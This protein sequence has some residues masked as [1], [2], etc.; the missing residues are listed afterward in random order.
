MGHPLLQLNTTIKK[1]AEEILYQKGLHQV[2]NSFGK[3][4]VSGSYSLDLMTWRDLDIYLEAEHLSQTDF[5]KLGGEISGLLQPVKM[6]FRNELIAK[7]HGLPAGIYWG[8][9]LGN[10]REGAWKI[11]IWAVDSSEYKRLNQYC[12]SIKQKLTPETTLQILEIKSKCWQDPAYRRAYSSTDI[13]NA[14][15]EN[16]VTSLQQFR[17]YLQQNRQL[18]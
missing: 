4:H 15:F 2:L 6:S 9:Y 5:F 3:P 17:T 10:E 18:L 7:T 13:Y 12:E 8:V 1:E 14:V 16:D 11:D